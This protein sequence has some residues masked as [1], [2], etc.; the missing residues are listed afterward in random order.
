MS[1]RHA[2]SINTAADLYDVSRDTIR[3]A[4]YARELPA[5][6]VGRGFRIDVASLREWFDTLPDASPAGEGDQ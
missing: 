5:K 6:K 3:K 4:I 1:D 2:V